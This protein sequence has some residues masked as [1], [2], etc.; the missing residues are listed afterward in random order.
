M[1]SSALR[2]YINASVRLQTT[3]TLH[4]DFGDELALNQ[5]KLTE[6]HNFPHLLRYSKL[7]ACGFEI[8]YYI[9]FTLKL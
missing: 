1:H 2:K 3:R 8:V 4:V 9:E 7:D 6:F 5:Q